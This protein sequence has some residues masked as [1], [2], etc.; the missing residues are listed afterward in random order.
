MQCAVHF[1]GGE[2]LVYLGDEPRHLI[3]AARTLARPP[4]VVVVR[5]RVAP[6]AEA[7]EAVGEGGVDDRPLAA[8]VDL[9]DKLGGVLHDVGVLVD[10]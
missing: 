8:P 3:G 5:R 6:E 4:F 9:V 10:Q 7:V 1:L 2:R